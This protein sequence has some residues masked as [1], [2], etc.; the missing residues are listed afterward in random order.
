MRLNQIGSIRYSL[1]N[2]AMAARFSRAPSSYVANA[3][4]EEVPVRLPVGAR[5]K[6]SQT[7]DDAHLELPT[8]GSESLLRA[9]EDSAHMF[10]DR[11][12]AGFGGGT[13]VPTA[14]ERFWHGPARADSC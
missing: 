6:G 2:A 12:G 11:R 10:R 5:A 9:I 7:R 14:Q 4:F 13:P 8:I 3:A 1:A